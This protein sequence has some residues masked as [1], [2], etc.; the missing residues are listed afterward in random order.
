VWRAGA[1]GSGPTQG[2]AEAN[3]TVTLV[4]AKFHVADP[5]GREPDL[6]SAS[7]S[8]PE[9]RRG[10]SQ[11]FIDPDP[12]VFPIGAVGHFYAEFLSD[13]NHPDPHV[14]DGLLIPVG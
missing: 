6:A 14:H 3:R 11:S 10:A 12:K 1:D 13:M 5:F 8:Q 2:L 4:S 9:C 7:V